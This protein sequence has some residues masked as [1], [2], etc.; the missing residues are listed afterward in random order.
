MYTVDSGLI[1]RWVGVGFG[2]ELLFGA[3]SD[4]VITMGQELW[5][6]ED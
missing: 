5:F 6:P 1:E 2:S 4:G 3:V